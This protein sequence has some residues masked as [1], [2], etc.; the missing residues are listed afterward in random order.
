MIKKIPNVSP[1]SVVIGPLLGPLN[2]KF[3]L[4]IILAEEHQLDKHQHMIHNRYKLKHL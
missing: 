3:A 1:H 4:A 2:S